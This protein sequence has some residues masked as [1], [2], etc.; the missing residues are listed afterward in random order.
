MEITILGAGAMGCRFGAALHDAGHN[1]QLVD[2]WAEHVA[3]IESQGGLRVDFDDGPRLVDLRASLPA[4]S[5]GSP[6]LI[7][8]FGKAMQTADLIASAQHLIS[9][10]T[11]ILTLQNG[12]GN[13]EAIAAFVENSDN[14]VAGVTTLAS[15]LLGPGRIQALGNGVTHV[16]QSSGGRDIA[17]RIVQEAF[18]GS[19]ISVGVSPDVHS[20]IWRKVAFNAVLNTL[21]TLMSCPVSALRAYPEF[22]TVADA[23][24]DEIAAVGAAEGVEIDGDDVRKTI[25]EA[26]D[27][28][29]S[30]HHLPSMLQDFLNNRTTEIEHLNGEIVRRG[31]SHR[32]PTPTNALIRHLIRMAEAT[33]SQ[34]IDA[35]PQ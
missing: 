26:T 14:V 34:R 29:M 19:P 8:V 27:P 21:C 15:E 11:V 7:V 1:V 3:A 10:S 9:E 35:L 30:G 16:M 6:D 13:I 22:W 4:S 24:I 18:A 12:L 32:V 23:V 20:M 25:L 2:P 28:E 31:D 33:R 5:S 17:T